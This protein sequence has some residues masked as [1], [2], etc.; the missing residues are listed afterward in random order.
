[1]TIAA[2]IMTRLRRFACLYIPVKFLIKCSDSFPCSLALNQVLVIS[3]MGDFRGRIIH[4]CFDGTD[5]IVKKTKL[6]H[7]YP[8]EKARKTFEL[9]L[10]QMASTP[11]GDTKAQS[12]NILRPSTPPS[13][14]LDK[15]SL[16]SN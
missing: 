15:L 7:F 5:I 16:D 11:I 9:F 12:H 13:I 10:R 8:V 3:F 14:A 6:Y 2:T 4:A 1:M